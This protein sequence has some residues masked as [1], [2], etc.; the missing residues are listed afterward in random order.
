MAPL[1]RLLSPLI[2]CVV[3][4]ILLGCASNTSSARDLRPSAKDTGGP[5][6]GLKGAG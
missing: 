2:P 3:V 4:M 5:A 6:D 1:T